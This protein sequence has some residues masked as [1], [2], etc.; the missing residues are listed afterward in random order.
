MFPLGGRT[1][2]GRSHSPGDI[3]VSGPPLSG[4]TDLALTYLSTGAEGS[5]VLTAHERPE[6]IVDS[7]RGCG[8]DPARLRVVDCSGQGDPLDERV[9]GVSTPSDLTTAGVELSDAVESFGADEGDRST[10]VGVALCS[11]SHLLTYHDTD[12]VC[13]FVD[14]ARSRLSS[15]GFVVGVLND[16]MHDDETVATVTAQFDAVAETRMTDEGRQTRRRDDTGTP[17][18]WQPF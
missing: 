2:H 18:E 8:G 15:E 10:T 11:L 14:A 7:F 5:V 12:Q 17:S 1:P 3:L 6:A 4:K 16:R 9:F 13:Q